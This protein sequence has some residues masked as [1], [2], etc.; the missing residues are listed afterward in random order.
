MIKFSV[1]RNTL[2]SLF[3]QLIELELTDTDSFG[4]QN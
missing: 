1:L 2:V 4:G 3:G